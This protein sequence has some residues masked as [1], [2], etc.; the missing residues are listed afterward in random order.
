MADSLHVRARHYFTGDP[1]TLRVEAGNF[2]GATSQALRTLAADYVAPAWC[3]IQINGG[4]GVGFTSSTLTFSDIEHITL[5]CHQHGIGTFCPT[6]ITS[7]TC[8]LQHAFQTLRAA[9][10]AN[11]T[12]AS[13][14]PC[15]HLEGPWISVE[16]G[17]RGAHP[18]EHIRQPDREVFRSLQDAAG[19]RIRL[20]TLAPELDGALAFIQWLTEQG[21]L[22]ALGHT[23]A[24]PQRIREAI[25]AGARLSTHLGNGC[26]RYLHRH[27]NL[28]WEQ[29]SADELSASI[30]AD[31]HHLPW[32]MI[33]T[34]IRAKSTARLVL[35][36]DSSDLAGLPPGRY[37]RW[38]QELEVTKGAK[39]V[40]SEQGV[41]AGAWV[42]TDRC[43]ANIVHHVGVPLYDAVEM[44]AVNPRRLLGLPVPTLEIGQRAEFVL[45]R[46]VTDGGFQVM[47][48]VIGDRIIFGS[49]ADESPPP[50]AVAAG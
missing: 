1:V 18:R 46:E 14:I 8:T 22:V 48:T 43:V 44:A 49:G 41:L 4:G 19:G 47:A 35:T 2:A 36:C 27:H 23:A 10:E 40:H 45:L 24:T 39:V 33:R 34:F 20:V 38:G 6:V 11:A 50:I 9:V 26:A 30:I 12:L 15:F 5:L 3:D 13:A 31:G 7:D 32:S 37:I 28:L 25:A 29:L 16:D 21:I 42:F 17:P